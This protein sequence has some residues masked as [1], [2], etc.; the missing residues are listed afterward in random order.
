[1]FEGWEAV[2]IPTIDRQDW[3]WMLYH[4][5]IGYMAFAGFSGA[6][7]AIQSNDDGATW[8]VLDTPLA[9]NFWWQPI[10][11]PSR[12]LIVVPTD[13]GAG[14]NFLTSG[15]GGAVWVPRTTGLPV[16]LTMKGIAYSPELDQFVAWSW[17]DDLISSNDL[18]A[19]SHTTISTPSGYWDA[20]ESVVWAPHL[21]LWCAI[22]FYGQVWTSTDGL[23]WTF[24]DLG[25]GNFDWDSGFSFMTWSEPLRLFVAQG[26][27]HSNYTQPSMF[28]TSPDAVNWTQRPLSD[29]G[30]V[31]VQHAGGSDTFLPAI[32]VIWSDSTYKFYALTKTDIVP[33]SAVTP[34]MFLLTSTDGFTWTIDETVPNTHDLTYPILN[35]QPYVGIAV[36]DENS[37]VLLSRAMIIRKIP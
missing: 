32:Q 16:L 36:K 14:T 31:L 28:I 27:H 24:L 17:T 10:Y 21:M 26:E 19:W 7:H 11:V 23:S 5:D 20:V 2:G 34:A 30:I 13:V 8:T 6:E 9:G 37:I 3:L 4:D 35:S 22:G 12:N 29:S 1:V 18:I 15:N 33:G 25:G